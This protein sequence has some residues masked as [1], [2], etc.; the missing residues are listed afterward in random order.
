M[1]AFDKTV[2][3][4]K[5]A[6]DV[7]FKKT[8]EFVSVG[9]QKLSVAN[10]NNK[11]NKAYAKLGKLQFG[12]IKSSDYLNPEV[13]K[14]VSEIKKLITE[15]KALNDEIDLAEGKITCS[16]CGSKAPAKSQFCNN[17]GEHF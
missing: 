8:E 12:Q 2:Q 3:K 1:D 6:F 5:D 4:T 16:K 10:L 11:L 7:V 13:A 9:K 17:C 14:V 15:I